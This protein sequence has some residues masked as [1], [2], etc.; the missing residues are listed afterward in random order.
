MA[1]MSGS[2][3]VDAQTSTDSGGD[4][5]SGGFGA[6]QVQDRPKTIVHNGEVIELRRLTP[7]EKA[8]RRFWRNAIMMMLG[9]AI[10]FFYLL[11][12]AGVFSN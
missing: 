2:A 9:G 6:V 3:A 4:V 8:R 11:F 7:E 5:P 12:G 1:P 10:L